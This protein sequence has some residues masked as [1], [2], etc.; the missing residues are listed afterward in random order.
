MVFLKEFFQKDDSEK[1]QQTTKKHE[2]LLDK[3]RIK[4]VQYN[5]C[6]TASQK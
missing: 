2:K 6:K 1:S 3:Q 4:Q 5:L